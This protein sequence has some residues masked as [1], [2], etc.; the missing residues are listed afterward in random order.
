MPEVVAQM[1]EDR[2][3]FK[4]QILSNHYLH[5]NIKKCLDTSMII[6]IDNQETTVYYNEYDLIRVQDI[7]DHLHIDFPE[8]MLCKEGDT[9][10]LD[11]DILFMY[12]KEKHNLQ[13]TDLEINTISI[14]KLLDDIEA[15]KAKVI[16]MDSE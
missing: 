7:Y 10:R 12:L 16:T 14:N 13:G 2:N 4:A 6:E 9:I 8:D 15:G 11:I 5:Y 1:L 3:K